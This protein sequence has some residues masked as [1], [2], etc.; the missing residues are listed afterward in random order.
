MLADRVGDYFEIEGESPYMLLVAPVRKDKRKSI[1]SELADARGIEMLQVQRSVVPAVTHVDYSARVQTIDPKRHGLYRK[2][3]EAFYKQTGCPVVVNT[4]FNLGW[5]PIVCTPRQ[6]YDTFMSSDIDVL[7]MGHFVLN[8]TEQPAWV[9]GERSDI[10]EP[11]VD[12]FMC[13]PCCNARLSQLRRDRFAF[14]LP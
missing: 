13:S 5:D 1:P 8:K 11:I 9:G 4:S 6:A 3:I 7:C 2:L 12:G 14:I 10:S